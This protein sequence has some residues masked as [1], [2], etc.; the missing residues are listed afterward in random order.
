MDGP[1]RVHW[2]LGTKALGAAA[3][4][5]LV[6]GTPALAKFA[7]T[8]SA[9]DETPAVGQRVT[10]VVKSDRAL[11]HNLRLIAVAPGKPVF[12]V[13]ATITG[14]TSYPIQ[15]V[16]RSGFEISLTRV[17]PKR[18][19]GHVRFHQPGRWHVVV[20]NFGPVGVIIPKGAAHLTLAVR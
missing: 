13:V 18:W 15:N 17:S 12:R 6:V 5:A 9:T 3:A 10:L 7:L 4:I 2:R 11:D 8:L 14:D 1:T 20:P 16:A 19:R